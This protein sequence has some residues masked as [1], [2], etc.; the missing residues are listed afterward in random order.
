VLRIS[1]WPKRG[2]TGAWRLHD[3]ELD[4]ALVSSPNTK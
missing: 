1:L 3:K 2:V 4:T